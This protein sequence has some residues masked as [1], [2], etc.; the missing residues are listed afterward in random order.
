M[1]SWLL[2]GL[3]GLIHIST[4]NHE[5]KRL[6]YVFK[7]ITLLL[8][9]AILV[10]S[11][12]E[13]AQF[14]WVAAGLI[15]SICADFF[16]S[17]PKAKVKAAFTTFIFA[18]LCYSKA[19]WLPFSGEISWWLP[20]LLFAT[21]VMVVLLLLPKLDTV[22][23]PVSIMGVILVQMVWAS[24]AVWLL[25]PTTTHLYACIASCI[26]ILATLV[27]ALNIYRT[28]AIRADL[29]STAGL[30]LGQAFIVA[31]VIA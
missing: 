27:R 15:L 22:V 16:W 1:W 21:G 13:Q 8:L 2:V 9:L 19:L 30:F 6:S 14:F 5:N 4:A 31:S 25:E 10:V 12:R 7:P 3:S 20:A 11:G 23:V 26:F 29:L 24:T 17:R 18:F 28:S